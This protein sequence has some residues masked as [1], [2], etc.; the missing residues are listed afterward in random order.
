MF[1]LISVG[2]KPINL[3]LGLISFRRI[4]VGIRVG[5]LG[6]SKGGQWLA[7]N[8]VLMASGVVL[9]HASPSLVFVIA[10]HHP[11]PHSKDCYKIPA[12]PTFKDIT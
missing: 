9:P 8:E 2:L 11:P 3:A 5:L 6:T 12:T 10:T 7:I 1:H 4:C